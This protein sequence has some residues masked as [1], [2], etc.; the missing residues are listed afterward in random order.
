M[1]QQEQLGRLVRHDDLVVKLLEIDHIIVELVD[2]SLLRVIQHP[3]GHPLT[4]MVDKVEAVALTPEIPRQL[5]I[6]EVALDPAIDDQDGAIDLG[7]P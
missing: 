2:I 7:L 5:L 6:L 1:G 3:V 4:A